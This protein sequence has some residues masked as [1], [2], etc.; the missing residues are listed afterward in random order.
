MPLYRIVVKAGAGS[1]LREEVTIR[2]ESKE[3]AIK[4]LRKRFEYWRKHGTP[5]QKQATI[6]SAEAD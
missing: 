4:V 2:A 5:A 1:D 6:E 3:E